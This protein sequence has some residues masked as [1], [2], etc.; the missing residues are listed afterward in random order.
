MGE[1]GDDFLIVQIHHFCSVWWREKSELDDVCV[2]SGCSSRY[3]SWGFSGRGMFH[4]PLLEGL[5]SHVRL[6]FQDEIDS[7]F[8]LPASTW[9]GSNHPL[10]VDCFEGRY[11]HALLGRCK[12]VF[13]LSPPW[14]AN[15]SQFFAAIGSSLSICAHQAPPLV[16]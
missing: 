13:S 10:G 12:P 15:S 14:Y 5:S 8:P 2:S 1:R 4:Y 3:H 6:M 16:K 7:V 11:F 9:I